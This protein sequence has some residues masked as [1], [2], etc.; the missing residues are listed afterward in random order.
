[1]KYLAIVCVLSIFLVKQADSQTGVLNF[2]P[3]PS[4]EEK[5]SCPTGP[6][7]AAKDWIPPASFGT[8][9]DY[10]NVCADESTDVSIPKSKF[11]SNLKA[12][13]GTSTREGYAGIF[14]RPFQR[15]L[16]D[17]NGN[18][19]IDV[20]P[21]YEYLK[22]KLKHPLTGGIM[23]YAKMQV[24]LGSKN[25][26]YKCRG[27][28]MLFTKTQP[29]Q[30][31]F[32]AMVGSPQVRE[33]QYIAHN[34]KWITVEGTFTATG[35]EEWLTIGFFSDDLGNCRTLLLPEGY[36]NT[37]YPNASKKSDRITYYFIDEVEVTVAKSECLC[38][39]QLIENRVYTKEISPFVVQANSHIIA[40][41]DVGS[42][43]VNGPV[44]VESDADVTY[45]AGSFI[46]I[47]PT[48]FIVQT[49]TSGTNFKC[50]IEPCIPR[51]GN[52]RID[53]IPS[54]FS[55]NV[56]SVNDV[57]TAFVFNANFV[58]MSVFNGFGN[59]VYEEEFLDV[60]DA[61]KII[62]DKVGK[63]WG[64]DGRQNGAILPN[65]V[66]VVLLTAFNCTDAESEGKAITL[67][68]KTSLNDDSSENNIDSNK[69]AEVLRGFKVYP[70]PSNDI[71]NFELGLEHEQKLEVKLFSLNGSI[72]IEKEI[73]YLKTIKKYP[74]NIAAFSSG[75]YFLEIKAKNKSYI[76]KIVIE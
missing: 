67:V 75:I 7:G 13:N 51:T 61:E 68:L 55:P 29:I 52:V 19:V 11:A 27:L 48:G 30:G 63:V 15:E 53:F 41:F 16:K 34:K 47:D 36:T 49:P 28:G 45:K 6:G 57:L 23:Y 72:L 64:W 3:N 1:M 22:V 42:P 65:D 20:F 40:G 50:I 12:F 26:W 35:G 44:I 69:L 21:E 43:E 25:I 71:I 66:F 37:F 59:L 17:D 38:P 18:H 32:S 14:I 24:S 8:T 76:Q 2:V 73:L 70:N 39:N 74:I 31:N 56:D 10:Y 33:G 4:F 9:Q 60:T 5:N 54:A 62:D 58:S 46:N